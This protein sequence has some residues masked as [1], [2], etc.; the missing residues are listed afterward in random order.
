MASPVGDPAQL[1]D[2]NVHQLPR[3]VLLI[4]DGGPGGAVGGIQATH[5]VSTQDAVDGGTGYGK[6]RGQVMRS[7]LEDGSPAEH[8]LDR[9]GRQGMRAVAGTR[10]PIG[11]AGLALL[12]VTANPFVGGCPGNPPR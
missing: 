10:G 11:Q 12:T 1:L 4:A 7:A 9:P 6:D 8:H 3:S 5:P 2:V